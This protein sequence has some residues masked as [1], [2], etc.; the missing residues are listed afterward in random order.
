MN[1]HLWL[2][3]Q[4]MALFIVKTIDPRVIDP[5]VKVQVILM[6]YCPIYD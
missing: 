6:I 3:G 2:P 5:G 1:G 4:I